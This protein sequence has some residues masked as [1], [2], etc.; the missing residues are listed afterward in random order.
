MIHVFEERKDKMLSYVKT[1]ISLL[2]DPPS[3]G[4]DVCNKI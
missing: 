2:F 1:G 4:Q 3:E